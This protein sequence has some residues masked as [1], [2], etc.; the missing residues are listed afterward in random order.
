MPRVTLEFKKKADGP[1]TLTFVR[2]DGSRTSAPIGPATHYGPVHDLAHY[3]AESVLGTKRG[4]LGLCSEGWSIQDFG[5]DT[6]KDLP[7]E[8][9]VAEAL[10][11]SL[12]RMEMM[13][14]WDSLDDFNWSCTSAL[15]QGKAS[16]RSKQWGELGEAIDAWRRGEAAVA[17]TQDEYDAMWRALLRLRGEWNRVAP[18]D[19]LRLVFE[20]G[21]RVMVGPNGE[22]MR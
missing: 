4:F 10:A 1:T 15:T 14:Q 21:A 17:V 22:M 18:G 12:S 6:M 16:D 2:E 3:V 9:A 11:G 20:P 19:T 8:A 13:K 7:P 5:T